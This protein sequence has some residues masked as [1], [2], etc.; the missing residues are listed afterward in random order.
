MEAI[1][2]KAGPDKLNATSCLHWENESKGTRIIDKER[3]RKFG[4]KDKQPDSDGSRS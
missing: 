2:N 1:I 3:S 4:K